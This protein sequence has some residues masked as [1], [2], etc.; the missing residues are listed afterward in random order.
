MIRYLAHTRAAPFFQC[1]ILIFKLIVIK[2][3]LYL[4]MRLLYRPHQSE[5]KS[6]AVESVFLIK[7]AMILYLAL[8][9]KH[10]FSNEVLLFFIECQWPVVP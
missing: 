3:D 7:I 9:T 8:L 4:L 5:F 1:G 10:T 6:G 2:F